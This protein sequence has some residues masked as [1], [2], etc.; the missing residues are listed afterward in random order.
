M[1]PSTLRD[2]WRRCPYD[3]NNRNHDCPPGTFGYHLIKCR[4]SIIANKDDP[5]RPR[6]LKLTQCHYDAT[7]IVLKTELDAHHKVCDSKLGEDIE[8]ISKRIRENFKAFQDRQDKPVAAATPADAGMENWDL[9]NGDENFSPLHAIANSE[10]ARAKAEGKIL[11]AHANPGEDWKPSVIRA[12]PAET[13]AAATYIPGLGE[14]KI[15]MT[16]NQKKKAKRK[17][18]KAGEK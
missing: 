6:V 11:G 2:G 10:A 17:T 3:L 9:E 1:E 15:G 8:V 13:P 18:K 12:K 4:A 16:K 14:K 7:H 5:R